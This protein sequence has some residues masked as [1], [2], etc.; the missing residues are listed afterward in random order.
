VKNFDAYIQHI[1]HER[2]AA[3]Q[4]LETA[5]VA[6]RREHQETVFI[7]R[8]ILVNTA[9]LPIETVAERL[10]LN[11][12]K[13]VQVA[14]AEIHTD[15]VICKLLIGEACLTFTKFYAGDPLVFCTA[16]PATTDVLVQFSPNDHDSVMGYLKHW[17]QAMALEYAEF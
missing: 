2:E 17:A 13:N 16:N 6:R 7:A 12:V 15:S 3:A 10:R 8:Q 14:K 5:A 9:Q 1:K 4:V 11:G